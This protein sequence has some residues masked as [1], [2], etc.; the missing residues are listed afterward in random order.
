MS[1]VLLCCVVDAS[2]MGVEV[3]VPFVVLSGPVIGIESRV[4]EDI[5]EKN[6][7]ITT[8]VL[9]NSKGGDAR[10]GYQVGELIRE[11]GLNTSLSGY[12]MSSCSRMFL[13][14]R[15]AAS[16]TISLLRKPLSRFT[17]IMQTMAAC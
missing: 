14:V 13:G 4:L 10:T 16:R 17:E 3:R 8:V 5:L 12:C 9:K 2:A 15:T 1:I 6:P 7:G 11:R